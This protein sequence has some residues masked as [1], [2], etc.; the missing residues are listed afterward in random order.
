[1]TELLATPRPEE[2]LKRALAAEPGASPPGELLRLLREQGIL[3]SYPLGLHLVELHGRTLP[4]QSWPA[5][6]PGY[7]LRRLLRDE[8]GEVALV[9]P[10]PRL[11]GA[12]LAGA[13]RA[14]RSVRRFTGRV[15]TLAEL[16]TLLGLA[17][18][19]AED[20][21]LPAT[22]LAPPGRR[23]YPSG[24]ALYPIEVVV[25]ATNVEGLRPG[26]YLYQ[27]L[28]HRLIR[29]AEIED[30][31]SVDSMLR[32]SGVEGA[33]LLIYLFMDFARPCLGKYGEKAYRLALLEAGHV[34]QNF[35]LV[36]AASKLAAVPLC[37]FDDE[38]LSSTAGL[39]FPQEAI[40]YAI[41]IG[42]EHADVR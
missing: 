3:V 42:E 27:V 15:L 17:A 35:L 5:I 24:G 31:P 41:A 4:Q 18:G 23:T 28:P 32:T 36:A 6:D 33:S 2:A 14:R 29:F 20:P 16:G 21:P 39:S 40:V 30:A 1:M 25:H 7:D 26:G 9:L 10:P 19:A 22:L 34:A 12:S 8:A 38:Q 37:G 11:D 13:L